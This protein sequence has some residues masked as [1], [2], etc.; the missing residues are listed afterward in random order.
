MIGKYIVQTHLVDGID[1]VVA[2]AAVHRIGIVVPVR[3]KE[4]E[5]SSTL[6]VTVDNRQTPIP[7]AYLVKESQHMVHILFPVVNQAAEFFVALYLIE[8]VHCNIIHG[9]AL[10]I[11]TKR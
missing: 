6:N 2:M 5:I 11:A 1:K 4:F 8:N 7:I 3:G 10:Q 9:I